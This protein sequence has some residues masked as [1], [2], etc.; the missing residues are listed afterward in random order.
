MDLQAM[1]FDIQKFSI[2]DGPGIRTVVFFK[3][4][5]LNCQ[6]CAN[7]E[8]N[9]SNAELLYYPDKCIGCEKCIDSCPNGAI[10]V[11]DGKIAFNPSLCKNCLKC[12]EKCYA[13][14]RRITGKNMSLEEVLS[15]IKKDIVFY[16][17]SGGGVTFSGGEPFLWPE[18]IR[19]LSINVKALG[20]NTAIETCGYFPIENYKKV[21]DVIDF[22]LFDIKIINDE[23]HIKY[24][25][26]SN[27]QIFSNFKI[28]TQNA[29]VF[30]RI[31]IIPG[32]N[33]TPDE[34]KALMEFLKPYKNKIVEIHLLPYHNLGISKY[35]ALCRP[36]L[37]QDLPI[38]SNEH[39]RDI[40]S[41]F[42]HKGFQTKIGG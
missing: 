41:R 13:A 8:S 10:T 22:I 39:M 3:G 42:V 15:E 1:V 18:F 37:L 11:V 31:P 28:I 7:P 9:N 35:D 6:W 2:H 19:E 20:A 30:V 40:K 27:R 29:D 25:G 16:E 32:I 17:S 5:P 24:C 14:A 12:A 4:C 33:D 21:K 23:K 26:S 36:Y 34:L 38:P